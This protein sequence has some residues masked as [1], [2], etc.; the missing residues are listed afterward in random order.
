MSFVYVYI[1]AIK[2]SVYIARV[3]VCVVIIQSEKGVRHQ[4]SRKVYDS[5]QFQAF[6]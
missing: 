2:C 3:Y 4:R 6:D 5:W 1:G